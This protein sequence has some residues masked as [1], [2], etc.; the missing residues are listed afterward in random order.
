MDRISKIDVNTNAITYAPQGNSYSRG[1]AV[2]DD[3]DVWV[4][5]SNSNT[6]TRLSNNLVKKATISVGN[7]PT[8]VAVDADGKVWVC[9]YGDGKINRI[10]PATNLIDFSVI[11]PGVS[12]GTGLHYSYSDMTGIIARTVTTQIG[13]WNVDFDSEEADTEWG[14]VSWNSNEPTGTSVIVKVRSSNDAS[15]WSAWETAT[16]GVSLSTTPDGRYLQVET[17]LQINSGDTS[18]ILYDLSVEIAGTE[19]IVLSP[20]SAV[21][22]IGTSHTVTATVLDATGSP[23]EGRDVTFVVISG[24]NAGQGATFSTDASGEATFTYSGTT[25]GTDTIE[26]TMV[27]NTQTVVSS[28]QVTKK[29]VDP[30]TEIPEFPTIAIPVLS[31]IGLMFIMGRRRD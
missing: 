18:P 2:T 24:P 22:D 1:V 23:I 30:N 20:E 26:A 4:A 6:A 16:D 31:I 29:W 3:G 5:N 14:K 21:N 19:S 10:N 13:T 7:T 27:D 17:K 8:G 25:V 12:G 11:T 9:N 15:T 28:N